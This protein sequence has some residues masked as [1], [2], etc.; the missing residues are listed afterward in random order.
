V[1]KRLLVLVTAVLFLWAAPNALA[2]GWCGSG[3]SQADLPD[4]T[5]GAQVHAVVA[6]PSDAPDSFADDANRVAD[7]VASMTAW[8]QG[9]DPT[10]I[11]R[12]D[13]AVFPGGTCLDISFVR[14][15]APSSTY[16]L[17]DGAAPSTFGLVR[18]ELITAG[19]VDPFKRYLV[20]VDG[21]GSPDD[22]VCGTGA[23]QFQ[24]GPAYAVVWMKACGVPTD[25]VATHELLHALG[26]LPSGAPNACT[27]ATDPFGVADPGHPCDSP[28]DI[29]YPVTA[30]DPLTSYVLDFNHDDYYGHSGTW[31]DIQDSRWL[32]VLATPQASLTVGLTG[33]PGSV[34][35]DLPGVDCTATCTTRWDQG[36]T[37]DLIALPGDA[38]RF[39]GWQ[40]AGCSGT[41][42][43]VLSLSSA[44]AVTAVFGPLRVAFRKSVA[45]KGRIACAPAC[46]STIEAGQPVRLRAVAA[47][48]WRFVAWGGACKGTRLVCALATGKP[49]TVRATFKKLPPK[50]PK[51]P[52]KKR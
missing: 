3:E 22:D 14:L 12:F 20:Y 2:A 25:T 36:T 48:G 16:S 51:K 5:T 15:S 7:D 17:A 21:V 44:Q 42:D 19:L 28:T 38:S 40:G 33:G 24:L 27:A 30:G 11:P 39:V 43:C 32:H 13:T 50:K 18:S 49:V 1:T 8:W 37:V 29:L 45:G 26:A 4:A 41:A 34:Q 6:L 52:T 9:Q 46:G 23:G 47:K 31:I 35:S 10:R